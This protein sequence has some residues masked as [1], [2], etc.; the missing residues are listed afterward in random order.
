MKTCRS[1]T[2]TQMDKAEFIQ[3]MLRAE[4]E[5]VD[6]IV[7][8]A[9]KQMQEDFDDRIGETVHAVGCYLFDESTLE[10]FKEDMRCIWEPEIES[11]SKE[12]K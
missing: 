2:K 9:S 3:A 11:V 1:K 6:T 5:T 8:K 7:S 10:D 4:P 12:A